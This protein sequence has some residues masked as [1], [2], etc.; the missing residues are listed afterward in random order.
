VAIADLLTLVNAICLAVEH[1]P[2]GAAQADR[3][4]TLALT[5][6]LTSAGPTRET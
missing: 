2:D 6:A 5:G 1:E 4:L 3:L